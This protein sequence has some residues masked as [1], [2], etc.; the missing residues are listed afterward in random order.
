M[1]EVQNLIKDFGARRA[2]DDVSFS[3][4][5]GS[6][7][8]FLGPNGAGKSTT[9]RMITGFL[10]PTSGTAL[11]AGHDIAEAPME[12]RAAI[13]YLPESAPHYG[14]MTVQEFLR[15]IAELRGFRGADREKRVDAMV[16]KCF[17]KDVVH[18]P[19]E[20]L[21]KGYRQRAC[22]A[23]AILHDPQVLIMDEPTDGLDPNQ[24]AMV[25]DMMREMAA[26]KVIVLST[27]VLEEVEAMCNR[28]VIISRG[29]LVA[30]STPDALKAESETGKLVDVFRTLTHTEDTQVA[31][32]ISADAA[33]VAS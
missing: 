20:T 1:L 16:E 6:V 30:D 27:H 5:M 15:F 33:E 11:V 4:E 31:S 8:G 13:G 26:D 23:Q 24:K 7:L 9:M 18:Q 22:F 14:E 21:S 3:V 2:V 32:Q 12:A 10:A 28:V 17:L 19:M 29:K 25:R